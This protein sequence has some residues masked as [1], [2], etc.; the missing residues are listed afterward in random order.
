MSDMNARVGDLAVQEVIVK[1]G[2]PG[3]NWT[4]KRLVQFCTDVSLVAGNTW[5]IV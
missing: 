2:V 3:V 1:F 4:G 5:H